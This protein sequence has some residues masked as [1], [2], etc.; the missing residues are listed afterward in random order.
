MKNLKLLLSALIFT[1]ASCVYHISAQSGASKTTIK[2]NDI[3]LNFASDV[4][5]LKFSNAATYTIMRAEG[6][7]GNYKTIGTVTGT[8]F[9]DKN[10]VGSPYNYYYQV[11]DNQGKVLSLL[12]PD[13]DLFGPDIYIYSPTDNPAAISKEINDIH[14]LMFHQEFGTDRYAFYFKPGDYTATEYLKIAYYTHIG[15]LGKTPYEV[16]LNDVITPAPLPNN[17]ATCTFWRSAENIAI[18]G[19]NWLDPWAS[20]MWAVSQAAPIR[21]IYSQ[22]NGYYQW[23]WDGWCSGGFTADCYFDNARSGSYSQQQWYTRNS[24]LGLGSQDYSAGGWNIAYQGVEFGPTVNMANHNDNWGRSGDT[25]WNNVSRVETTPIIREKPFLFLGD[26]GRYKVFKPDLR[27]PDSKGISW[28]STDMGNGTVYDLLDDFYVVKPGTSSET[29]NQQLAG[30]KFLFITPGIYTLSEPLLVNRPNTIILGTGYATLIPAQGNS[31]SAIIVDDVDGVTI[32]SLLFDAQYNSRTLMQVGTENSSE[33]HS[34]NP[35]LLADLFFRVGGTR[36]E[37]VHVDAALVINSSD[38]IGD[39]F[40]IW[41]ADHGTGVGWFKNTAK[42]GLIVNGDFV[43]IYGL[44]NEHFQEYQTLWNGEKGR[45]YFYQSETPYD[46]TRQ[47]DYMSHDGTVNGY[48]SYKVADHVQWHEAYMLGIYDVF[49]NTNGASVAVES[50]VE[51]PECTGVKVHNACNVSIST[52]GLRGIQSVINGQVRS[53]FDTQIGRRYHIVDFSGTEPSVLF[54]RP[55]TGF[56]R[57]SSGSGIFVYLNPVTK[58]LS[59]NTGDKKDVRVVI[60]DINGRNVYK[61]KGNIPVYMEPFEKGLYLVTITAPDGF[62]ITEKV[63]K[64]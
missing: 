6:R 5:S 52:P 11:T 14:E 37:N 62:C 4:S 23:Q 30:G 31:T 49:I 42:N 19:G 17:N 33:D 44:F 45:M 50:S 47:S 61:Q 7:F 8:T 64:K 56:D 60:S 20:F 54:E 32:A 51:V 58:Y 39:H 16:K 12:A 24:Y 57:I 9:I 1:A 35:T 26:D 59:I 34:Q 21:R 48:A 15:G 55:V 41:R 40:W 53:T 22:R 27:E 36:S 25:Q 3:I 28:S 29:M 18:M 46:P 10:I 43:T 63:I 38:V 2:G 13:I